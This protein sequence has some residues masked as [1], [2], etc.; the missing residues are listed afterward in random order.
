MPPLA[1]SAVQLC[2]QREDDRTKLRMA[3]ALARDLQYVF[4]YV[5][6]LVRRT[7]YAILVRPREGTNL[8]SHSITT[9]NHYDRRMISCV[10]RSQ[11]KVGLW[12]GVLAVRPSRGQAKVPSA[13][14]D[15][16]GKKHL[17]GA[18]WAP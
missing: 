10:F 7:P 15:R 2:S 4:E 3:G 6:V 9:F 18:I 11:P 8:R 13:Q 14:T 17:L 5:T 1:A 12:S 16:S